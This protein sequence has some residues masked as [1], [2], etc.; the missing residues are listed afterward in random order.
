KP[1]DELLIRP[2]IR[3]DEAVAG[4]VG[5]VG[6]DLPVAILAGAVAEKGDVGVQSHALRRA[7]VAGVIENGHAGHLAVGLAGNVA[8]AAFGFISV[9]AVLALGGEE[10]AVVLDVFPLAI[11]A[12][13]AAA[14]MLVGTIQRAVA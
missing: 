13:T 6:G 9:G 2:G 14:V 11:A 1:L 5:F 7:E 4:G 12:K 10:E 3:H 8:P